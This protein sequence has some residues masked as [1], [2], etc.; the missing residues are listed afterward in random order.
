MFE[1]EEP[2]LGPM[3]VRG[4]SYRWLG[5]VPTS[6]VVLALQAGESRSVRAVCERHLA[7]ARQRRMRTWSQGVQER[8]E[9][10]TDST[11]VTSSLSR[12]RAAANA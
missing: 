1:N 11:I 5:P 7:I 8:L 3:P 4:S 10:H 6:D 12:P 2:R 9:N